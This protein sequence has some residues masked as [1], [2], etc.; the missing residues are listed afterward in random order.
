M[1]LTI[2]AMRTECGF[3]AKAQVGFQKPHTVPLAGAL[4]RRLAGARR[5]RH[6]AGALSRHRAGARR[7][8]HPWRPT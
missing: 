3:A 1:N 2:P 7:L 5:P 6:L 8:R 4:S